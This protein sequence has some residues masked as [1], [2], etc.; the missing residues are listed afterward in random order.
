MD[1]TRPSYEQAFVC[2]DSPCQNFW[3]KLKKSSKILS[4]KSFGNS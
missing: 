3:N 1:E 2:S 4:L